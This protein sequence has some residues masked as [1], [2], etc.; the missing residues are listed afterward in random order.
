MRILSKPAGCA[1]VLLAVL[2]AAAGAPRA[3]RLFHLDPANLARAKELIATKDA[4]LMPAYDKL[5]KEADSILSKKPGSVMDKTS[6]PPSGDKHDYMSLAPYDWPDPAKPDGLPYIRKDGERNPEVRD[7]R[8]SDAPRFER[9]AHNVE[10]LSL[11]WYLSGEEKY[12]VKAESLLQVWF[13]DPATAMN[14]NFEYAQAVKGVN[15]GS[16]FGLIEARD[17]VEL[18]DSIGLLSTSK[19][20][21]PAGDKAM[22]A[23][24]AK[25]FQWL[26]DSKAGKDERNAPNNHGTWVNAQYAALA[27]YLGKPD[28]AKATLESAKARID[29][30]IE[31]DGKQPRELQRTKSLSYS[32][33]NLEALFELAS[34]GNS[35]GVDLFHYES[36]DGRSLRK[37]L[38]FLQ[39]YADPAGKWPYKQI[40]PFD[41]VSGLLP[42]FRQAELVYKDKSFEKSIALLPQDKASADRS[43]LLYPPD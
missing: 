3:P 9:M 2:Q 35:A 10:T 7:D 15:T 8:Y 19:S 16:H 23:W 37:A 5:R 18:V 43:I 1:L 21:S 14:P 40:E 12:A 17:F 24:L 25:Y 38:G 4:A 26:T 20:W 27:L 6:V 13:I 36:K 32:S 30:Q 34:L 28:V 41:P 11:A 31:P 29:D 42:L 39:P 22:G 33:F